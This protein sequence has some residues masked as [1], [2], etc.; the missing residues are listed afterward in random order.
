MAVWIGVIS[1][2][3]M[4]RPATVTTPRAAAAPGS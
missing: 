1:G 2:L 4:R 3:L